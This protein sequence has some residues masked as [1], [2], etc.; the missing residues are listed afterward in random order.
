VL[1]LP[2]KDTI[3]VGY[4]LDRPGLLEWIMEA[5]PTAYRITDLDTGTCVQGLINT[6]PTPHVTLQLIKASV[7]KLRNPPEITLED[8][9][10]D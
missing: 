2:A 9:Y 3:G 4:G 5:D 1:F 10:D 7:H 6:E 8:M